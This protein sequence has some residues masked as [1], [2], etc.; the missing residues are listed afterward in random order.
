MRAGKLPGALKTLFAL[1]FWVAVWWGIA[2]I[3]NR[4]VL[5]PTP[6][7]VAVR[8][9]ELFF[10]GTF[11]KSIALSVLRITAGF[12]A[13]V[14]LGTVSGALSAKIGLFDTLIS[15]LLSVIKATPVASFI[16]LALVWLNKEFIPVFISFLMVFPVIHGN[17]KAGVMSTDRK[18]LEMAQVFSL[19][20]TTVLLKIYFPAV[21][22]YFAAGVKTCLG[23]AWKAGVASEVLCFPA[24]SI[25]KMLY[26]AKVYLE[27]VDLFAWTLTVIVISVII[28]KLFMWAISASMKQR[29][30]G[31][32]V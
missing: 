10:T 28:E 32:S 26:G 17:I 7:R 12:A 31:P 9:Y 21:Y 8:L 22:P 19:K 18:L 1:L 11:H 27:T 6:D 20:K 3:V 16:I 13:A 29:K 5:I 24:F 30:G 25:G 15:P 14:L 23:L 4:E 2:L